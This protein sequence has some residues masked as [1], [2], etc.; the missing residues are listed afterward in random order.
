MASVGSSIA[1]QGDAAVFSL[2]HTDST[3][4]T[5]DTVTVEFRLP[6]TSRLRLSP[7]LALSHRAYK[8]GS[9]Q[10]IVAPMFRAAYRWPHGHQFELEL[11]KELANRDFLPTQL[12]L[13]GQPT[14]QSSEYFF[15]AGYWWGF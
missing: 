3:T 11:G 9:D 13:L 12:P 8:D 2:R 10:T 14:E 15:N 1:K 5:G 7:R 6:A 4:G